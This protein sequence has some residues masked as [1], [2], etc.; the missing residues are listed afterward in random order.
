M[1]TSLQSVSLEKYEWDI[2]VAN[3]YAQGSSG[4]DVFV[5]GAAREFLRSW[6]VNYMGWEGASYTPCSDDILTSSRY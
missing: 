2:G 1:V 4:F 5:D 6:Q 3:I